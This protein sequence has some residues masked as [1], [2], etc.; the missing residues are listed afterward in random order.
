MQY[1]CNVCGFSIVSNL[2][3]HEC[4]KCREPDGERVILL[5]LSEKAQAGKARLLAAAGAVAADTRFSGLLSA[6]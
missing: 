4:P 3:G 6:I 2:V 5:P 1:V